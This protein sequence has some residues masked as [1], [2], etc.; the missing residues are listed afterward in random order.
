MIGGN[1]ALERRHQLEGT[2]PFL[3]PETRLLARAHDSFGVRLPLWVV[4]AGKSL[5]NPQGSAGLQACCRGGL[6]PVVAHQGQ[7]LSAGPRAEL[8]IDRHLQGRKPMLR[9]T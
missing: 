7:A 5:L 4:I 3:Q 6:T 1:S 9:L 2:G 8:T